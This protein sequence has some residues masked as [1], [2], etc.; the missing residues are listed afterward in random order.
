MASGFGNV[1]GSKSLIIMAKKDNTLLYVAGA[2][3]LYFLVLKPKTAAPVPA[4]AIAPG[5]QLLAPVVA[6][7]PLASLVNAGVNLIKN[8][9]SG[10]APA[11]DASQAATNQGFVNQQVSDIF[12]TP[13]PYPQPV[14]FL[15][16]APVQLAVSPTA[17]IIDQDTRD[18]INSDYYAQYEESMISGQMSDGYIR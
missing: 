9:G 3:A 12:A 5:G 6:T 17:N 16:P 1:K 11:V 2:A 7:N 15:T 4:V 14:S 18:N 8:L 10:G 13:T